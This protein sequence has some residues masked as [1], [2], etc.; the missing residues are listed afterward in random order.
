MTLD[1]I[2]PIY[3]EEKI[4]ADTVNL[5]LSYCERHLSDDWRLLLAINGSVDRSWTI[6]EDLIRQSPRCFRLT[7]PEKGKGRA[8]KAGALSSQADLIVYLD[9]DLAVDLN[10]LKPLL[11]LT[12]SGDFDLVVGS[13]LLP[14]SQTNRGPW[15]E[16]TSRFYNRL[17]SRRLGYALSDWQCGFKAFNRRKLRQIILQVQADDWFFDTE[18]LAR[19]LQAGCRIGELPIHWSEN[20]YARRHS[21]L[22]PL[23][24]GLVCLKKLWRLKHQLIINKSD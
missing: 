3:N 20:R 19:S 8:L 10:D 18:F 2:L 16:L 11:D 21:K 17:V 14:A 5:L 12:T 15:R 13:R 9:A 7:L 23:R 1:I 6:A 4:L 22:R 24:D